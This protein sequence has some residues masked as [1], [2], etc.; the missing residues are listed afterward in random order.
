MAEIIPDKVEYYDGTPP[1]WLNMAAAYDDNGGTSVQVP[2]DDED[3]IY[4]GDADDFFFATY[5]LGAL[6]N[7]DVTGQTLYLWNGS[8]WVED[9]VTS[10][11]T[12]AAGATLGQDG[13][14]TVSYTHL[15]L[16][17]ILLV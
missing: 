5:V 11:T 7:T 2:A 6:K 1:E 16:P 8:E 10:D 4:L 13:S 17:T 15:T 12:K 3:L 14:V 9:T